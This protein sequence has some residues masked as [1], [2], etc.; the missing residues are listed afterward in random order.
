MNE[1]TIRLFLVDK[2]PSF[3]TKIHQEQYTFGYIALDGDDDIHI[4]SRGEAPNCS[5]KLKIEQTDG[6]HTQHHEFP[7]TQS[8]FE[9]LSKPDTQFVQF[10][11]VVYFTEEDSFTVREYADLQGLKIIVKS[12]PSYEEAVNYEPQEWFGEEVT[13]NSNYTSKAIWSRLNHKSQV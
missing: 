12:F 9:Q 2:I 13:D 3:L 10:S 11:E 4:Q 7:I 5:F 1:K 6:F 8:T